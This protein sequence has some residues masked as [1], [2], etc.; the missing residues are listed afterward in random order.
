MINE[1]LLSMLSTD[2]L[3]KLSDEY[4]LQIECLTMIQVY[5]DQR[6]K[7]ALNLCYRLSVVRSND[8]N[9]TAIQRICSILDLCHGRV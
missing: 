3:K 7:D 2:E 8:I 1:K 9:Y 6:I 4:A 5:K